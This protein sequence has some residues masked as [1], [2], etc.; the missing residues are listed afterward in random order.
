[1]KK[2]DEN[3]INIWQSAFNYDSCVPINYQLSMLTSLLRLI[4]LKIVLTSSVS[5]IWSADEDV[6]KS[7][8]FC[9]SGH[10]KCAFCPFITPINVSESGFN[11]GNFTRHLNKQ[12]LE[13]PDRQNVVDFSTSSSADHIMETE[14]VISILS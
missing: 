3:N 1:V 12:T 8:T 7:K 14:D 9:R 4:Q 10:L 2:Y 6:E 13:C 5:M 11:V